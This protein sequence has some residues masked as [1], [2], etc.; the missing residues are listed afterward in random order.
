MKV[1]RSADWAKCV[2]TKERATSLSGGGTESSRSSTSASAPAAAAFS[3][4]SCRI[5]GT[6]RRL[7]RGGSTGIRLLPFHEVGEGILVHDCLDTAKHRAPIRNWR[8][9]H[10]DGNQSAMRRMGIDLYL[11][12]V[13]FRAQVQC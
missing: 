8:V 13:R 2:D 5:P 12:A 4:K 6:K 11:Q 1:R 7:R 10:P 9:H 3:K